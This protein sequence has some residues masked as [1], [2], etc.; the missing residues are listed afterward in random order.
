MSTPITYGIKAVREAFNRTTYK[1]VGVC[2]AASRAGFNADEDNPKR[3]EPFIWIDVYA[4]F[5][6]DSETVLN[7]GFAKRVDATVQV[8]ILAKSDF[9]M[10][11]AT[12]LADTDP[13]GVATGMNALRLVVDEL[14]KEMQLDAMYQQ[15]GGRLFTRDI[16]PV[17]NAFD[18]NLDGYKLNLRIGLYDATNQGLC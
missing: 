12:R 2:V 16:E 17:F 3:Y 7:G 8:W 13:A 5:T 10:K 9:T 1:D 18:A 6:K 4:G 11:T 14:L 15:D